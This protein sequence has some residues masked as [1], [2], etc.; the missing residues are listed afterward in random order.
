MIYIGL[1]GLFA[2]FSI[3]MSFQYFNYYLTTCLR[4]NFNTKNYIF[5]KCIF[6]NW[7]YIYVYTYIQNIMKYNFHI[8]NPIF[9]P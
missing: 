4:R 6:I 3:T 8:F 1:L 2:L 9:T 7:F 5:I